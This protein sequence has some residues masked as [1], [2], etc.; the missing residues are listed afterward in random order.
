M[1]RKLEATVMMSG[2]TS[3]PTTGEA[4]AD[5]FRVP[6]FSA[7]V[8]GTGEVTA[9]VLIE[10]SNTGNGWVPYGTLTMSGTTLAPDAIAGSGRYLQYR[11]RLTALTGTS[12]AV[13][14]TMGS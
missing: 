2:V 12:A 14:V 10:C 1:N 9:T 6:S 8:A 5:S 3:S 11:A 4:V 13:T 7:F